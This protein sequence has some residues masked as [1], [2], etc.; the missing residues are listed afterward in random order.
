VGNRATRTLEAGP[1]VENP[2]DLALNGRFAERAS[3]AIDAK[4]KIRDC[5]NT[6]FARQV[7]TLLDAFI[8]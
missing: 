1:E 6:I 3:L 5:H 8:S 7:A 2:S 4:Q